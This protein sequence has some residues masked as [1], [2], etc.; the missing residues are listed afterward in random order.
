MLYIK[1][2]CMKSDYQFR[3]KTTINGGVLLFPPVELV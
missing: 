3:L 1:G 2:K